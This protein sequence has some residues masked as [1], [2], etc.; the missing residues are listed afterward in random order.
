MNLDLK[1]KRILVELDK[2]ARSS[3]AEIGRN[4]GLSLEDV[5]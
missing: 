4:T 3:C 5:N 1:D 2:N